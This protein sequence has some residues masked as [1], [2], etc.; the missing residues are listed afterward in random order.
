M[1]C[2]LR[3]DLLS[4]QNAEA[5]RLRDDH[6]LKPL[7]QF[8]G[9]DVE[10]SFVV[11]RGATGTI[12]LVPIEAGANYSK[13]EV[14]R[15]TVRLLPIKEDTISTPPEPEPNQSLPDPSTTRRKP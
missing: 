1:T 12:N 14:Q 11:K 15:L 9:A 5:L 3:Q 10:V 4:L 8:S 13:E 6:D 7:L 2:T